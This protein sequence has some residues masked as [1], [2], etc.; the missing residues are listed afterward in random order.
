[1]KKYMITLLFAAAI[2]GVEPAI[3]Q[4]KPYET[5]VDGVKVIVQPSGNDIVSIE[6]IIKGGVANYPI[7]K[8]GI[9]SLAMT[10]LTECGTMKHDKNSFKN[11]LDKVSASIYGTSGKDFS[12]LVLNCLKGDLDAVWPLYSEALTQPAFDTTEF[13]RI[14]SDA[15]TNL[16]ATESS[17]D[18]SIDKMANDAAFANRDYAKL[19]QG[20]PATIAAL[21]AAQTKAYYTNLLTKARIFIVVVADLPQATIEAKVHAM[22]IGMKKGTPVEMKKSFFRVYNNTIKVEQKDLATNY[23][24]GITSGPEVDAPDFYAFAVAMRI[25]AARHFLDVRTNNGLSYAPQAWFSVGATSVA[26]FSVSTTMP[27]K[28]IAV[29][30]KLV[31]STK[32]HGFTAAELADMKTR[33]LTVFYYNNETNSAQAASIAS[34]QVLHGDWRKSLTL[35]DDVKKVTL[36]DIN[37]AFVKYI[38]NIVWVYQ[39]DPK[40][41]N[42]VLYTNGTLHTNDNPVA[43]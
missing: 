29:F 38:N 1:M 28:Y 5:M 11:A 40:K 9:E 25:F 34:N 2:A 23:V 4:N 33:Y 31:D 16:K 19:P 42:Q 17:P 14:K 26:K 35:V 3:A 18:A 10:A 15:I 21:T 30:D 8:E 24:E 41:V 20:T 7:E 39:G 6:T 13:S 37:N 22:L 27:D 32:K 36:E 43:N 12:A